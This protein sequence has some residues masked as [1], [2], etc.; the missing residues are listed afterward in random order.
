MPHTQSKS[1]AK[2]ARTY[3]LPSIVLAATGL[4]GTQSALAVNVKAEP[5]IEAKDP[6]GMAA[7]KDGT[8]FFTEKCAGLSVRTPSGSTNKLLG[9]GGSTGFASVKNDLFCDGQAGVLGVAVDPEFDKNRYVY[10]RSTSKGDNRAFG[11]YATILMRL[12]VSA[13]LHEVAERVAKVKQIF[14]ELTA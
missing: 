5:F 3:L 12:K 14:S 7:M 8:F 4:M 2:Q 10:L 9:I 6:W 1:F 11:G 13:D